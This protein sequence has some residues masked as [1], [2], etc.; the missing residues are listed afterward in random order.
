MVHVSISSSKIVAKILH[1]HDGLVFTERPLLIA[2]ALLMS[3]KSSVY[4]LETGPEIEM[5]GPFRTQSA[6]I[7]YN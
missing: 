1:S 6:L 3:T 7:F 4:R 5:F 2:M